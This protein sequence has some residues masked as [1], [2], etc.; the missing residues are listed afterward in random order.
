MTVFAEENINDILPSLYELDNDNSLR[1]ATLKIILQLLRYSPK[2]M[3]I[4]F[5]N[6]SPYIGLIN[7]LV[8]ADDV[9]QKLLTQLGLLILIELVKYFNSVKV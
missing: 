4:Y 6:S 3:V 1:S 2:E 9:D 5:K 7:N 8:I